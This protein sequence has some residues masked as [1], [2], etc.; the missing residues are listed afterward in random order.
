ML[1]MLFLAMFSNTLIQSLSGDD[2]F[3]LVMPGLVAG[4]HAFQL[5]ATS[6]DMDGRVKPGYDE[7]SAAAISHRVAYSASAPEM[8][9]ISSLVMAAWRVRL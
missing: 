1:P 4:I 2:V 9:S 3:S 7:G 8:I 6:A 5:A